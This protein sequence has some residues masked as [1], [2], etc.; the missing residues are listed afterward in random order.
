VVI[1]KVFSTASE[2][3]PPLPLR[4]FADGKNL[5]FDRHI[6]G[7]SREG[8][9]YRKFEFRLFPSPCMPD[10]SVIRRN[11]LPLMFT[12]SD[13]SVHWQ[14][15]SNG[16][17]LEMHRFQGDTTQWSIQGPHI[18]FH[19]CLTDKSCILANE[20]QGV[21]VFFCA[22]T[23]RELTRYCFENPIEIFFIDDHILVSLCTNKQEITVC[24]SQT[25]QHYQFLQAPVS[26]YPCNS[27]AIVFKTDT[28]Q[29]VIANGRLVP[30]KLQN[31]VVDCISENYVIAYN[32]TSF[33]CINLSAPENP[34]WTLPNSSKATTRTDVTISNDETLCCLDSQN[35]FDL[36]TGNVVVTL[37]S[38]KTRFA[39]I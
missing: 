33:F 25:R 12:P 9:T 24:S 23:G 7:V 20:L 19:Q 17:E 37:P 13:S 18:R 3:A 27:N 2:D 30:L 8:E 31:V 6:I 14:I 39:P 11:G 10:R 21:V 38:S 32:E 36:K 4:W 16:S 15:D 34:L 26:I 22:E 5:A 1:A 35:V 28:E 29:L